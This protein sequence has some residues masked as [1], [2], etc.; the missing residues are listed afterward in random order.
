MEDWK[1]I[2]EG[3]PMTW[4]QHLRA[5]DRTYRGTLDQRLIDDDVDCNLEFAMAIAAA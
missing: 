3:V 4:I 5:F 1:N 2:A